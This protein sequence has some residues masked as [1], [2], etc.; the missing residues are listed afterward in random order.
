MGF[1]KYPYT[2]LNELNLDWVIAKIKYI[3]QAKNIIY[4]NSGTTLISNNVQDAIDEI[5][6][7]ITGQ[8]VTSFN[9][10]SGAVVSEAGDYTAAQVT[11]DNTNTGYAATNVQKAIDE[12]D[13]KIETVSQSVPTTYVETF[14][15]RSGAVAPAAGDYNGTQIDYDNTVSQL[16]ATDVQA[17]IDEL[18][19]AP[20]GVTSF[21]NRTGAVVPAASDYTAAQ[22][23]FDDT[24]AQTGSSNVQ[25]AL[26]YV[27]TRGASAQYTIYDNSQSGLTATN[28]QDAID[29]VAHDVLS[30]GVASFNGRTGAVNPQSGDYDLTE[31][32][33]VAISTPTQ[34]EV[35]KYDAVSQ[36]WVNGAGGG[37]GVS[38]LDDLTDVSI[39]TPSAGQILKYDGN[40]WINANE[41]G[42]TV[43]DSV[44]GQDIILYV[45]GTNGDDNND[46]LSSL[47]PKK[48][49]EDALKVPTGRK[50]YIYASGTIT[51]TLN[52]SRYCTIEAT[53]GTITLT[54]STARCAT[55]EVLNSGATLS[56]IFSG[57]MYSNNVNIHGDS[58]NRISVSGTFEIYSGMLWLQFCDVT[59]TSNIASRNSNF[60]AVNCTFAMGGKMFVI[61]N[62]QVQLSSATVTGAGAYLI[63]MYNGQVFLYNSSHNATNLLQGF[64]HLTY[65][66]LT[67]NTGRSALSGVTSIVF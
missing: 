11:Y 20:G 67:G 15:N 64:G 22:V 65:N 56:V 18:A 5:Y 66:A 32:G 52:I 54:I 29:E 57:D 42:G 36:K 46:G 61:R 2:D 59:L 6:N 19:A 31:L 49:I 48:T 33:D 7:L 44:T 12:A 17:A 30:S 39:T 58:S 23:D 35:L 60:F 47:T 10:R 8:G 41:S 25:G 37:G 3:E 1:F 34:D 38:T 63:Q 40:D 4:D 24:V 28:V 51:E 26:E 27:A 16:A 14:N 55:Y 53:S 45:D 21:N 13:A 50:L 62:G 43:Y 9:G